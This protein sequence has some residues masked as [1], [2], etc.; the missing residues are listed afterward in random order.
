MCG[1][2]LNNQNLSA[3]GKFNDPVPAVL[4]VT[5]LVHVF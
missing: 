3:T 4:V 1:V 2:V 5:P